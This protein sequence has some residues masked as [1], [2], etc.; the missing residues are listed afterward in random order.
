MVVSHQTTNDEIYSFHE[1]AFKE[2]QAD[3]DYIIASC[4]I[5]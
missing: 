4:A 1:Q 3:S 2:E 5:A